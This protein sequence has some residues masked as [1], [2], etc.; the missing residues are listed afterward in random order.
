MSEKI[1]VIIPA[2]DEAATIEASVRSALASGASEVILSDGGSSD[3]TMVRASRAGAR[4]TEGGSTRGEQLNLGAERAS[5]DILLFLHADTIL[6]LACADAVRELLE[7]HLLGGFRLQFLEQSSR[8]R[9]AA[10]MIN[11]R[12][13]LTRAPW[14]DQAQFLR[15]SSFEELGGYREIPIMEDYDL[16]TRAKQQGRTGIVPLA[17]RTSGRRFLEKGLVATAMTNWR[18]VID[19]HRGVDPEVLATRYR[20]GRV[21]ETRTGSRELS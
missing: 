11:F 5:G 19:W 13:S 8:L 2:I 18:T 7:D 9:L 10:L 16:V 14:G 6:P 1:S 4:V 15:R 21:E 20:S 3:D 12:C 17:V